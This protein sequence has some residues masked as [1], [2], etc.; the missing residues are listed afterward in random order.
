MNST[1]KTGLKVCCIA[2]AVGDKFIGKDN[3]TVY[4]VVYVN[5]TSVVIEDPERGGRL[6]VYTEQQLNKY[7]NKFDPDLEK[8]KKAFPLCLVE[9]QE[10]RGDKGRDRYLI[11]HKDTGCSR[12]V[13]IARNCGSFNL[14]NGECNIEQAIT[15][16]KDRADRFIVPYIPFSN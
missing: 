5:Q 7:Y 12:S 14:Y 2:V 10:G 1:G 11:Y 9:F 3:K 15:V 6:Y 16:I 13:S 8:L 4:P